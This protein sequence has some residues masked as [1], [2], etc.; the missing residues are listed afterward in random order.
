MLAFRKKYPEKWQSAKLLVLTD[1]DTVYWPN[2]IVSHL[3]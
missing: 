1:K 2:S 3:K